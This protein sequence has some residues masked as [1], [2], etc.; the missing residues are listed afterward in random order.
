MRSGSGKG[1]QRAQSS[2]KAREGLKEGEMRGRASKD[3]HFPLER[4]ALEKT[5]LPEVG[6]TAR[7]AGLAGGCL[8]DQTAQGA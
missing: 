2:G 5:G 1:V 8:P 3:R 7:Q 6:V 4:F